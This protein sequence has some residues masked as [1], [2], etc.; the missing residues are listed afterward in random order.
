MPLLKKLIRV[1][2][3]TVI[4]FVTV[5]IAI[6]SPLTKYLIQK[7]DVKYTGRETKMDWVYVN[8]FT[9]YVH[10]KNLKVYELKGDTVFFLQRD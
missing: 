2:L 8:P 1:F 4:V 7:Y 6:I 9:G 5:V 3:I 10:F